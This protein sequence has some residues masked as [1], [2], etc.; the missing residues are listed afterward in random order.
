MNLKVL[1]TRNL[2]LADR[3]P[4]LPQTL[5]R[6]ASNIKASKCQASIV[7]RQ[8]SSLKGESSMNS[9]YATPSLIRK[10]RSYRRFKQDVSISRETLCEL[11]DLARLSPSGQ[12]NQPLKYLVSCEPSDNTAVFPTLAWAGK[13]KDWPG[14]S[15][16]ERPSAYIVIV[17]DTDITRVFGVDHGIAA[18]SILL[19]AVERGLG[20][21][22]IG[23]VDR[24]GL[25]EVLRLP[26][27]YEILL[28]IALGVPSETVVI[29]EL[30][31]D[32]TGCC[33]TAYW[34]DAAG[35]HHVPKRRLDDLI[36]DIPPQ[37]D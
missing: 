20:G 37:V 22:M 34:R 28:V 7:K 29:D 31:R 24:L 32:E 8:G 35:T 19:G 36:L 16:G 33:D 26:E 27:R 23:S 12:N 18:Q 3:T 5:K 17:G 15:D 13:L 1:I 9:S 10:N 21:C 14:P 11:I 6:Q 4:Q 30:P 2:V 25:R